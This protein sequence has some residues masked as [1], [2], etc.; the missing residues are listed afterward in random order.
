M[1][2]RLLAFAFAVTCAAAPSI[3]RADDAD[4]ARAEYAAGAVALGKS[5]FR[6]AAEHFEVAAKLRPHAAAFYAAGKAWQ[7]AGELVKSADRLSAALERNELSA[8]DAGDA[9]HRLVSIEGKVGTVNV[10][11][12]RTM[13]LQIDDGPTVRPPGARHALPG[14]HTLYVRGAAGAMSRE[15]T[16]TA[17]G[18]ILIDLEPELVKSW[19]AVG[20]ADVPDKV[21]PPKVVPDESTKAQNRGGSDLRTA[22]VVALVGS[23]AGAGTSIGLGVAA[24][25]AKNQFLKSRTQSDFDGAIHLQTA[26]NVGWVATSVLGAAGVTLVV[27]S[28]VKK[29]APSAAWIELHPNGAAISGRF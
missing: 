17:G 27:L 20:Q 10:T 18:A 29:P 4:D 11:G 1:S 12:D 26:T 7:R 23:A 25:S 3:A 24:I 6:E 5:A 13:E 8:A 15:V 16:L 9:R 21:E 2:S 22:G 19:K 28:I 14:T